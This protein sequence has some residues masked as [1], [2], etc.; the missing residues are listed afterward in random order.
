ML[1][2]AID[3]PVFA[4]AIYSGRRAGTEEAAVS[5]DQVFLAYF[6]FPAVD[7]PAILNGPDTITEAAAVDR[8]PLPAETAMGPRGFMSEGETGDHQNG[9]HDRSQKIELISLLAPVGYGQVAGPG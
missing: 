8:A 6:G 1:L 2:T 9:D 5:P 7:P 4:Q 3:A